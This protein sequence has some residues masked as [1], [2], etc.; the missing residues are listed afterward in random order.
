LP[1]FLHQTE[2]LDTLGADRAETACRFR[3]DGL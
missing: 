2:N 3:A 1:G